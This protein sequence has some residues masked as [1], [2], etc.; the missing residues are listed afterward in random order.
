[1]VFLRRFAPFLPVLVALAACTRPVRTDDMSM[2]AHRGEVSRE[3]AAAA[4]HA[5]EFDP[6]AKAVRTGGPAA[7]INTNDTF[8]DYNPTTWHLKA[9]DRHTAHALEHERAAAELGASEDQECRR[10]SPAVRAACPFMGPIRSVEDIEGG[11][12]VHLAAGAPIAAVA[13]HMRCHFAFARGRAFAV[14]DCP[15]TLRGTDVRISADGTGIDVTSRD[16][17]TISELRRRA[18]ALVADATS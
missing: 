12:R 10:F 13:A 17:K 11:V 6:D 1:M 2:Q 5:H 8:S 9:A 15:L 18:G 7:S 4:A 14:S 3:R 16:R